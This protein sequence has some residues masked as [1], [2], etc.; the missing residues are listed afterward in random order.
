M[1]SLGAKF[2]AQDHDTDSQ[3][4]YDELPNGIYELEIEASE[5][6]PTSS[7]NGLLLKYTAVVLRPESH[8]GR[9]QFAN[10]NLENQNPVAQKIGQEDFAK[11]C[12]AIG[13]N[14]VEDSEELHFKAF[15][16]KI[17][18]GKPSKDGHYPARAEIKRYYFPDQG[19]MPEPEIDANQPSKPAAAN[20]NRPAARPAPSAAAKPAATGAKRPWGSK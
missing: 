12:R 7:G 19:D 9:K 16:V 18:L 14:E 15:T 3:R 6:K 4:E 5:V 2:N 1:A 8:A 10:I 20:D 11:L 17:G 13:V